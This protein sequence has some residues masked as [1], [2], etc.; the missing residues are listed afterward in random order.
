MKRRTNKIKS[1]LA[2]AAIVSV[3]GSMRVK[4]ETYPRIPSEEGTIYEAAAYKDGKFYIKGETKEAE[5]EGA[6]Y[7]NGDKYTEINDI[8]IEREVYRTYLDKYIEMNYGDYYLDMSNGELSENSLIE[9]DVDNAYLALSRKIRKNT[10]GRYS[11]TSLKNDLVEIPNTKFGKSWY[12]TNYDGYNI[13]TD[14]EGNYIDADYN[15]G[16]I[17]IATTSS[18]IITLTNTIDKKEGTRA[19]VSE[20]NV[21]GQDADYI[22][23]TAKVTIESDEIISKIDG[24]DVNAGNAFDTSEND[25]KTVSFLAIQ[26]ISKEQ[27]ED[28]IDGAN[29]AKNTVTYIL[30]GTDGT[31]VSLLDGAQ[32]SVAGGYIVEYIKDSG[33]ITIQTISLYEERGNQNYVY[34]YNIAAEEI[35]NI[36]I[37][38]NGN[39]WKVEN[40]I[41]YKFDN[42]SEWDKIYKVD[43]SMD[44]LSVYDEN[45][46]IIWSEDVDVYSIKSEDTE[47][48]KV[49][50]Y[51]PE[52]ILAKKLGWIMNTDG[53]WSYNKPEYI[54]ATGWLYDENKWYYLNSFGIMQTGWINENSKWYHLSENGAMKT[55]WLN[56]SG[57]WYYLN[58]SGEMLYDTTV[59]GYKLGINGDLIQ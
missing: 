43:G 11:E 7:L 15:L 14:S 58:T 8:D 28:K 50:G 46:M 23:R 19:Y 27:A 37:D 1:V 34:A 25:G 22:Y 48:I 56:E 55:G 40:G 29:Y 17:K 36:D 33:T 10:K 44:N 59:D 47:E 42:Y 9:D 49:E 21:I 16:K 31:S 24:I 51:G 39:L 32:I 54:K 6:Y 38:T 30:S 13:Y 4:A 52:E 57:K 5:N 45:H 35:K 18:N 3:T 26:K 20:S 41:V 12:F 53:S 2:L